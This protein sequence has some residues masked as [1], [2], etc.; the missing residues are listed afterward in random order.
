[1]TDSACSIG[2]PPQ[3]GKDDI[4]NRTLPAAAQWRALDALT[5]HAG[6]LSR[7]IS[8]RV[9]AACEAAQVSP[10]ALAEATGI[11][12][13]DLDPLLRGYQAWEIDQL[14]AVVE[15]LGLDLAELV[16][17]EDEEGLLVKRTFF[18]TTTDPTPEVLPEYIDLHC[19][20]CNRVVG[21]ANPPAPSVPLR[22]KDCRPGGAA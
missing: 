13:A 6:P 11:A 5:S 21:R 8:A 16:P 14:A 17:L 15:C 9:R 20:Q 1:M 7:V 12:L 18:A 22:C 4:E 3:P 10:G 19:S 2:T